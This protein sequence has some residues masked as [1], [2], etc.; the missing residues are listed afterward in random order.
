MRRWFVV[1]MALALVVSSIVWPIASRADEYTYF[2]ETGHYVGGAFRDYWNNNGG[3]YVF[4][5]PITEEYIAANGRKTQWFERARF[6][7]F[8]EHAGTPY[9]VQLGLLGK[10][11]TAG[12][13]FPQTPP[14]AN[15]ANHRYFPETSHMIMWGFKTIWE[16]KGGLEM[17]GYPI[18]EEIMEI[19]PADGKWHI[20]QYFERAR[21][22]YW[23]EFAPGERVLISDLG[24]RLAPRELMDP[25]PPGTPPGTI[26][27]PAPPGAP[28]LPPNIHAT[29]DPQ[30]GPIGTVFHF[31]AFGFIP[32]ETISL[33]ATAPDQSVVPA[34]FQITADSDGTIA[35]SEVRFNAVEGIPAGIWAI[36]FQGV[37]SGHA[38]V[39]FFEVI[40]AAPVP[41]P[42]PP[43]ADQLPPDK[44]ASVQPREGPPGT[45]FY[46]YAHG[47]APYEEVAIGL[48]DSSD[49]L[50]SNVVGV[51]ADENG[52]IDYAQIYYASSPDTPPGIYEL[53]ALSESYIEAYAFLRITS[54]NPAAL[55]TAT[56]TTMAP[57]ERGLFGT[58]THET[59][60]N[61]FDGASK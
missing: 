54:A 35:S 50:V 9:Y 29:V 24:R 53:Y 30:S 49:N 58:T 37:S 34:E 42:P 16:T 48:F 19:L 40:G 25:L 31:N 26:P 13:V 23:P 55:L 17:F 7:L 15:D 59:T 21:F 44:N 4:G 41:P 45:T 47:F 18:S 2:P 52:S 20:V 14:R 57:I 38:A 8:P 1:F 61:I 39:A 5:F 6:E 28:G 22:E 12:R 60:L 32:G 46:F 33:W 10:E 27:N 3:L 43:P 11:A 51:Y 36:T 56:R